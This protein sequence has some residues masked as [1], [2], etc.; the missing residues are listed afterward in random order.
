[1]AKLDFETMEVE[2]KWEPL[3]SRVKHIVKRALGVV[4]PLSRGGVLDEDLMAEIDQ[5]VEENVKVEINRNG[6]KME[7]E[8]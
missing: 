3:E 4:A 6:I 2:C 8:D 7:D 5:L 1:M